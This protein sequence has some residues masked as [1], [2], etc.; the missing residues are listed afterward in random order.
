MTDRQA[1]AVP[2]HADHPLDVARPFA[3]IGALSF[4]TG[5]WGVMALNWLAGR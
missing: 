2:L 5:F 1:H 3:W 4:A